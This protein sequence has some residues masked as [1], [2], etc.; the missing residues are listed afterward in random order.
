M[1]KVKN[2]SDADLQ[3]RYNGTDYPFPK[4]QSVAVD[5]EVARH[6]FGF[7]DADKIPYLSRLGWMRS[8]QEYEMGMERLA[9]FTFSDAG[10]IDPDEIQPQEQGLAPLQLGADEEAVT[11]GSVESSVP[12]PSKG[13]G[14]KRSVLSQLA[15]A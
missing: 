7:G 11:D 6:I 13:A 10:E 1:L 8:N 4:G 14:K 2:R 9:L 3:D 12:L 15:G 5:E